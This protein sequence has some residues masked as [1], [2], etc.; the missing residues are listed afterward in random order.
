MK[1]IAMSLL[2]LSP[3]LVFAGGKASTCD[4]GDS[5]RPQVVRV[6]HGGKIGSTDIYY[7]RQGEA[8]AQPLLG[9]EAED[10]RGS[11]VRVQCI[12]GKRRALAVMGDFMSAGYPQGFV[13][14]YDTRKKSF[15]RFNFA[16]KNA[17]G[18]LYSGPK[19][20][21]L[22]FPP[23]G[24]LQT[25]R[26]YLVYRFAPGA[27]QDNTEEIVEALPNADGYEVIKIGL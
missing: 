23:G 10:S 16:E 3:S 9:G 1:F 13:L 14:T 8:A 11:D 26:R 21:L 27:G 24:R 25:E 17:P 12:G 19:D 2:A 18:W 15:E 4:L 6:S 5:K 20:T 7:L 22:V